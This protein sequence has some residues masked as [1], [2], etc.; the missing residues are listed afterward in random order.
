MRIQLPAHR[1]IVAVLAVVFALTGLACEGDPNDPM[2][3][4]KQIKNIRTQK[5]ALDHLA[6]MDVEKARPAVPALI[7]LYKDSRRPEHVE[8]L[9]RY[10]DERTKPVLIEALDYNDE[11]F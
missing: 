4:A 11:D 3:W 7:E 5:E 1:A 8:A 10:R 9:A 6:N 2:T